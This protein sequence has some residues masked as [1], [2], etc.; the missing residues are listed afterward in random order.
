MGGWGTGERSLVPRPSARGLGEGGTPTCL[1]LQ[2]APML[3]TSPGSKRSAAQPRAPRL[4]SPSTPPAGEPSGPPAQ[5]PGAPPPPHAARRD[6]PAAPGRALYSP[7]AL[8]PPALLPLRAAH[9]TESYSA[10][11]CGPVP[12]AG[13]R[14]REI[15]WTRGARA[16]AGTG[17]AEAHRGSCAQPAGRRDPGTAPR[18]AAGARPFGAGEA[19]AEARAREGVGALQEAVTRWERGGGGGA[20]GEGETQPAWLLRRCS[21]A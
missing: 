14:C 1:P 21:P 19:E 13:G 18:G 3:Q 10:E 16:R 2:L 7:A 9:E 8:R 4:L 20:G 12:G 11:S 17:G 6:C 5:R 15:T